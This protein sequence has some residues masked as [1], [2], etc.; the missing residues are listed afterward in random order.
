[1]VSTRSMASERMSETDQAT[2]M[3]TL[4]KELAEMKKAHE[5]ATK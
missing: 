3:I 2:M 1:M 5:E 4:Q